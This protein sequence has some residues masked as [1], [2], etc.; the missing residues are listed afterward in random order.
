MSYT[1]K[2]TWRVVCQDNQGA[3][4]PGIELY[5]SNP[6]GQRLTAVTDANGAVTLE[7]GPLDTSGGTLS[8]Y[9]TWDGCYLTMIDP[10]A[11]YRNDKRAWN[12][13]GST[14]HNPTEILYID[15]KLQ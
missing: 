14:D 3:P 8:D 15:M 5:L 1:K 9:H 2:R 6:M 12:R 13:D 11:K 7:T 10:K 4:V